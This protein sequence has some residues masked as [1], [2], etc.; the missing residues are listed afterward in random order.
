[1]SGVNT[2]AS[3][4]P[5]DFAQYQAARLGKAD[6]KEDTNS[7]AGDEDPA[8]GTGQDSETDD[9]TELVDG[10]ETSEDGDDEGEEEEEQ[11]KPKKGKG[12]FQ[13]RIEK[14]LSKQQEKDAKIAELEGRL[15]GEKKPAANAEETTVKTDD[16][17][18]PVRPKLSDFETYEAHETALGEYEEKLADWKYEQRSRTETAKQKQAE[19]AKAWEDRTA[20]VRTEHPDYDE[21]IEALR[22]PNTAAV[23]VVRDAIAE[24]ELGPEL[25]YHLANHPDEAKRILNLSP[26]RAVAELGKIE[27]KLT[28]DNAPNRKTK[29]SSAPDPIT[30]VSGK[31]KPGPKPLA[32]VDDFSEYEAR[33]KAGAK[34]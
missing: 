7:G 32:E 21:K 20:K 13:K 33:R 8:A 24:S 9:D 3:A 28:P 15:A 14:L 10:D 19:A 23:P 17:G 16:D 22:I 11:P 30:P 6:P 25:L 12:G 1:M 31:A 29:V 2:G 34:R 27:A 5:D 26:V 18:K 4:L